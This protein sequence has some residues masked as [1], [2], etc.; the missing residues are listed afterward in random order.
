MKLGNFT[1]IPAAQ[2]LYH[3]RLR[4]AATL[5]ALPPDN[6]SYPPDLSKYDALRYP[7]VAS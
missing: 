4:L 6:R 3:D 2:P 1:L 7:G 5:A